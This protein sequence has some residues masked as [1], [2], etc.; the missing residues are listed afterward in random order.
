MKSK[1]I[2]FMGTPMFCIPLL[3][4]LI[5]EYNV[6]G[7]VSKP[8]R[9]SGRGGEITFSP[10]KK[11][12]LENNIDVLQPENIK[13]EYKTIMALKPQLIITCA[14]GQFIPSQLLSTPLYGAINIHASLLPKLRGGAPIHKAIIEG[15]KETGISIMY[16]DKKMDT[17]DVISSSAIDIDET[18][19]MKSLH[20]KLAKLAVALTK[21][22]LPDIFTKS[23]KRI[24]Q[25]DVDATYAYN[26]TKEEEKVNFN[27]RT[28]NI[29]N[30]I[31]G[32]NSW[33]GAYAILNGD[34]IKLW[35][36]RIGSNTKRFR[37]GEVTDI[38]EDGIGVK[39]S[40]GEIIITEL[41]L[42]GK[43]RMI[44]SEYIRGREK[45]DL[46]KYKFE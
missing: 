24:K 45:E 44:A 27:N 43:K 22:T 37:I 31:R 23:N 4:F 33:P 41:Q 19:T 10:V 16:M 29:Y 25:D 35:Q 38:Y 39:T 32:L 36:S 6:V 28:L 14:Y 42:A 40:D 1:R 7:V 9:P 15:Y 5:K 3:K 34:V 30:Q 2:V 12:A 8:D 17:G 13:N 18:D 21:E 11:L 20:D 46:L 26:I